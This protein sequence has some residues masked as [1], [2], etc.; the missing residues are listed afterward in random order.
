VVAKLSRDVPQSEPKDRIEGFRQGHFILTLP[1]D[2]PPGRYT[3]ESVVADQQR[4]RFS[5]LRA[6]FFAPEP[7][8][9][10]ALSGLMLLRRIEPA[11]EPRD[12][13][14]PLL[15]PAG[16]IVPSLTP[17][18]PVSANAA[19]SVFFMLYPDHANGAPARLVLDLMRDG[20][21]LTRTT[22]ELP[23]P[24]EKGEIPYLANVPVGN[25]KPGQYEF[26]AT[27]MQSREADQKT[28]SV[29]LQ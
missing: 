12:V 11:T 27:V 17:R 19:L 25:L 21:L 9:G 23:K 18:I 22:P 15:V 26:R 14:D 5:A 3:V 20:K 8:P 2:L 1:V 28:I 4:G 24:D 13:R 6:S 16:R 10:P 7:H 29:I